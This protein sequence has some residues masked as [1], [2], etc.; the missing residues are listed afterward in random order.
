MRGRAEQ[1]FTR[2]EQILLRY[3]CPVSAY[4]KNSFRCALQRAQRTGQCIVELLFGFGLAPGVE[5]GL[6]HEA[7]GNPLNQPLLQLQQ[8]A[9]GQGQAALQAQQVAVGDQFAEHRL[10]KLDLQMR[11]ARRPEQA[12]KRHAAV[13]QAHCGEGTLLHDTEQ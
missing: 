3:A 9:A 2:V 4:V 1:V 6:A 8:P 13:Q 5:P 7:A 10:V 11:D 12:A